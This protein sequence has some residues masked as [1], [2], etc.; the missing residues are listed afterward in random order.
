MVKLFVTLFRI[1]NSQTLFFDLADGTQVHAGLYV[2]MH[3]LQQYETMAEDKDE[4]QPLS[5]VIRVLFPVVLQRFQQLATLPVSSMVSIQVRCRD[6]HGNMFGLISPLRQHRTQ[7]HFASEFSFTSIII[8][9]ILFCRC[10]VCRF[11]PTWDPNMFPER[12]CFQALDGAGFSGL[13]R[14]PPWR[15]AKRSASAQVASLEGEDGLGLVHYWNQTH[16]DLGQE[17]RRAYHKH[18]LYAL[19]WAVGHRYGSVF[20][21]CEGRLCL[22][23][24]CQ[25]WSSRCLMNGIAFS[26][27]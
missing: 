25:Y 21:T 7:R 8:T 15:G 6:F 1:Y 11:I 13:V 24:S 5:E 3:V 27:S 18:H 26:W 20:Q 16:F 12:G 23:K 2:L 22:R 19:S 14:P 17:V 4:R 10:E 9:C